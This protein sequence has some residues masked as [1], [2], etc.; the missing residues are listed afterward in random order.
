MNK[1]PKYFINL[2]KDYVSFPDSTMMCIKNFKIDKSGKIYWDES[3]K[4][5]VNARQVS[6]LGLSCRNY[7][8]DYF[9]MSNESLPIRRSH[10]FQHRWSQWGTFVFDI[11][12]IKPGPIYLFLENVFLQMMH[13]VEHG[14]NV[15][16][17]SELFIEK[18]TAYQ[19]M[20]KV[21]L[22]DIE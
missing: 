2:I 22:L 7:L 14:Q 15:F 21:D 12:G 20:M 4:P 13:E 1:L 5:P 9:N 6:I 17:G 18:N 8:F 10:A 19:H 11:N 3:D 16:I